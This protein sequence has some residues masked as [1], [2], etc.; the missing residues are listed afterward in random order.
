MDTPI[1][2]IGFATCYDLNFSELR[3][4][5]RD[6]QP[7]LILFPSVFRG[8]LQ[9]QWWGYETRSYLVSS[10][11]DPGSR[12]ISPVGRI[13]KEIDGIN[14]IMTHTFQL[15]YQVFHYDYNNLLLEI[16]HQRYGNL[17]EIDSREPEG[18]FLLTARGDVSIKQIAQ[19]CG[20]EEIESYFKRARAVQQNT[21]KG[22]FPSPGPKAW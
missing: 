10:I 4:A 8:G 12:I 11:V 17:I 18:V 2:R 16:L 22:Q 21:L 7:D 3:L 1:G 20:L 19:D 13:I 9:T 5:Y 15:D 6:L 14:S